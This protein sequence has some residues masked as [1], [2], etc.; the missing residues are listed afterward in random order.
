MEKLCHLYWGDGKGKTTAAMGLCLRA[1]GQGL[2]VSVVQFLK[3]GRSG[4]L[5]PLE[6][7]GARVFGGKAGTKFPKDMSEE[8]RRE[9]FAFHTRQ[10]R[11]ALSVPCDL[12]LLDEACG[13]ARFGLVD[14]ELLRRAVSERAYEVVLTGRGPAKW[15]RDAADYSTEMRCERHPYER[16]VPAR[17]G[18]EF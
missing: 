1:L 2:R 11:E 17:R 5:A 8:E 14:E 13:A 12:L 3:D 7:L 4:E 9:A 10:L 15:M 18:V 16:G 6:R